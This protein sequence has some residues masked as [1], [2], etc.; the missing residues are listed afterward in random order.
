M[1]MHYD[2][3][4]NPQHIVHLACKENSVSQTLKNNTNQR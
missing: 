1:S 3:L 2:K 4:N